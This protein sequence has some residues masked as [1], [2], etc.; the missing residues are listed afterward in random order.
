[1]LIF[2]RIIE[3]E[4]EACDG[5]DEASKESSISVRLLILASQVGCLL[6][7][8]GSVIK[9]MISDSGAQIRVLAREKIPACASSHDGIVQVI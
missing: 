1:M 4:A 8:G 5:E 7:K 6:G 2:E 3:G 9:Q